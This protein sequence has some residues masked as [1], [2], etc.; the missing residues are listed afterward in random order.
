MDLQSTWKFVLEKLREKQSFKCLF[1]DLDQWEIEY[2]KGGNS[3]LLRTTNS[4][5][6]TLFEEKFLRI[7][8][9]EAEKISGKKISIKIDLLNTTWTT[10]FH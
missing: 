4:F 7:A 9:D 8:Q 6:K 2:E 10:S 3:I 1:S 5:L